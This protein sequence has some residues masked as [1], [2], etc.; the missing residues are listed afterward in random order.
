MKKIALCEFDPT[1]YGQSMSVDVVDVESFREYLW[2]N[3]VYGTNYYSIYLITHST[4]ILEVDGK[5]TPVRPGMIV[6][7]RPGELWHWEEQSRQEGVYLY[8]T[9]DFLNSFFRDPHFID[10]F[11]FFQVG[12]SSSFLYPDARLFR[13]LLALFS[14]MREEIASKKLNEAQHIL[15]AM[16]YETL[17]LLER[18]NNI[19]PVKDID[20]KRTSYYVNEFQKIAQTHYKREHHVE[21]YA[22]RLYITSNYLNKIVRQSL[23]MSTKQYLSNLLYNESER[24]LKYTMLTIGDIALELNLDTAYFIKK[25][26]LRKSITPLQYRNDILSI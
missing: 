3:P 23:G 1:K 15:R 20:Y 25:F 14:Q 2:D 11:T 16:V 5:S 18:V 10:S 19:P 7:S 12:R 4:E 9:D 26:R 6:C 21:Y 13:R 24:L 8:W 17:M 22:G